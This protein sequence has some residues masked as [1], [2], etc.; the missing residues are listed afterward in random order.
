MLIEVTSQ[1]QQNSAQNFENVERW[2]I[3]ERNAFDD[4]SDFWTSLWQQNSVFRWP[5]A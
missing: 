3:T 4:R 2:K 1:M 5:A